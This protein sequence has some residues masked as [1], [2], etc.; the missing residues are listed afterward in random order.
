MFFIFAIGQIITQKGLF[1]NKVINTEFDPA[2][3]EGR[4]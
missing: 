1:K 3:R 2:L 4:G